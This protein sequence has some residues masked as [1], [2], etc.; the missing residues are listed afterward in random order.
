VRGEEMTR[1]EATAMVKDWDGPVQR[2]IEDKAAKLAR[3]LALWKEA[4]SIRGTL[5]ERYLSEVRKIDLAALPTDVDQ[6][7]RFHPLCPFGPGLRHPCLLALLRNPTTDAPTGIHRIALTRAAEKI[8]RRTLGQMGAVKLWPAGS[9]LVIGEGIETVL[10]AATRIPYRGTPLQPAWSA[11]STGLLETFPILPG[12]ERL[13]IL[14]DNDFTGK[15]AAASCAERWSRAG[16]TV[17]R[18][19]PKR[20]GA[21]F[22]DLVKPAAGS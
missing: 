6:V 12:C 16:R 11:L 3:A 4:G 19:T 10:A 9:R 13:I 15:A 8:D 18:L 21:D 5:A 22:N 1:E 14:V 7:L 20:A 17:V 2:P